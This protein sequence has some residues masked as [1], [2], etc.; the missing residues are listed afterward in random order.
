MSRFYASIQGSRGEATR[1]GSPNSGIRGHIRSWDTGVQV[2]IAAEGDNDRI[3][4]YLTGGSKSP[5]DKVCL[6]DKTFD[7]HGEE[8]S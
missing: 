5:S 7:I 3:Q 4:V 1:Q 6:L 2:Y 8:V